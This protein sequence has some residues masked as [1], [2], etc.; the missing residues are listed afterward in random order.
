ML[1][2]I[3]ATY[4]AAAP[5]DA[6]HAAVLE[7]L[8]QEESGSACDPAQKRKA[9]AGALIRTLGRVGGDVVILAGVFDPCI[10]G[11]QNCP[12]Y[13]IRLTPG[14]PRVLLSV[15]A[16]GIHD[17][18][19]ARPLPG[20]VVDMHDSALIAD[21]TTYAF[22]G[23]TYVPIANARVRAT[24]HARKPQAIPVRFAAGASSAQLHG[25]A[26]LGWYDVYSFDAAKGQRVTVDGVSSPA[27][28]RFQLSGPNG[29]GVTLT[30]GTA[31]TL[32]TSGSYL[33][34]VDTDSENDQPYAMRLSIR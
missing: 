33:L 3:L 24:D 6:P 28:M 2:A 1:A 22:R 18:D 32:P 31:Y 15:F 26:S 27:T 8:S 16:I 19:H 7:V 10:C 30:R 29:T 11:A 20:L 25:T 17:A 23:G 13:A 4:I 12:S 9:A 14:K 21:Q 34:Q 5:L